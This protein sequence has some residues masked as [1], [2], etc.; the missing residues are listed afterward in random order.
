MTAD[1]ERISLEHD[2]TMC[3]DPKV[4]SPMRVTYSRELKVKAELDRL[5]IENYV[6]MTYKLVNTDTVNSHRELVPA[7]NNIIFVH[8]TQERFGYLKSK[9][10][11]LEL[12]SDVKTDKDVC[13]LSTIF[14]VAAGY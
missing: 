4:W 1:K 6:P 13:E 8:S 2:T 14:I 7:I 12:R 11:V 5:E 9:N 3:G 10:N